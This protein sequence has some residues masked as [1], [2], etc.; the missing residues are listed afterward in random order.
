[1]TNRKITYAV[2]GAIF[3]LSMLTPCSVHA[4]KT[5]LVA[6]SADVV[7]ISGTLQSVKGFSWNQLFDFEEAWYFILG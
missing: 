3:L 2:A 4:K 6:V 7:E 5:R 1:M